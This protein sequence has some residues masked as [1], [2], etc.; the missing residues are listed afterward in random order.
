VCLNSCLYLYPLEIQQAD[1]SMPNKRPRNT[2]TMVKTP[3]NFELVAHT[4]NPHRGIKCDNYSVS[5]TFS[6]P[7]E[8]EECPLTLEAISQSKLTFL[9]D[10]PFLLD[11]PQHS[12]VRAA[13]L[14]RMCGWTWSAC[15]DTSAR[16]SR[17]ISSR[18]HN[19]RRGMMMRALSMT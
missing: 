3:F 11:R 16:T 5:A 4:K 7:S 18:S 12:C 17:R 10:V 6:I 15:R 8:E 2:P 19:R 13:E 1:L 9:P 14:A